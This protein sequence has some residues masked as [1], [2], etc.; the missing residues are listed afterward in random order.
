ME[1]AEPPSLFSR[2]GFH[3]ALMDWVMRDPKFK[4]QLFRFVDVLP[5][6]NSA[7]EVARH[8]HEYLGDEQVE[9]P[10][11]LRAAL[12][13]GEFAGGLLSGGIRSQVAS[14]A[15]QFMLGSDEGEIVRTLR[16]LHERNVAFTADILGETVVSEAE[17]DDYARRY[18]DLLDLLAREMARWPGPCRANLTPRGEV[19]ALNLSIKISALYS[20]IH[21]ADPDTAI[22]KLATRL[23]PILR[24]AGE[25][26][27]FINFDME[28]YALKDLTL[29]LFKTVFA[30]PEFATAPAC[31]LA[32]QA[33]MHDAET[34]LR[35][36]VAWA[37]T[38]QRRIT[39]RLVKGAYWDYETII[40][41]QRGWPVPVFARKAETDANFE[42]LTLFLLENAD[43][44][45]AAF[46]THNVRS[47]AHALA[48]ADRLGVERHAIE[49]QMLHG[50]AGALKSALLRLDLRVREYCPVGELLPGMAY[51][52][53]RLL[54][55]TSNEGFLAS[56]FAKGASREELLKAPVGADVR[57]LASSETKPEPPYVGS[58]RSGAIFQN[59][60]LTDFTR[61]GDREKVRA[62][63]RT[64]RSQLGCKHPLVINHKPVT[65]NEW[66]PS[67]NPA[68][69][70]EII[71][72]AARATV[73]D[74][75]AALA[76][77]RAAQPAWARLP[78]DERAVLLE[79]LAELLRRDKVAL[80]ALEIL[81]AGKNWAE[82]DAD[83]AEAI[84]FCNF[85]AAEMRV[86]GQPQR[87]QAVAGESNFQ[88]W[89][90]RGTGVVIAPWN[91]PLAILTGMATAALVTG[92]TVLIKPS[93]QTPVIG[94]RLMEL[95]I[96][97]GFPAGVANLV[98]GRGS[99]VGAHLVAHPQVD[100]IAFTGSTEVGQR[101]WE[102]AGRT[103]PGQTNLKRAVCEMGGKNSLI[104]DG[105][106]DLDEAVKGALI[107]AFGYQ[108]QKCS[109]LSRLIVLADNYDRFLER[110][111][112]AMASLR[113]G[114]AEEAG[115]IIGPVIDRVA[116]RRILEI[117]EVG[118]AE[119]TLAWQGAVSD[120]ANACYVPPTLFTD[121]KPRCRIFREEIFGPVLCVS[122]AASFDEALALAND[123]AFA[124]TGGVYSRSP[125]NIERAKSEMVCGNL[126]INRP[127]TGAIVGRQPFGG[128]KMSGGGTKAGG[129]EYLLQFLVPRVVSENCLRRGFAPSEES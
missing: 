111:V 109:A 114:P 29:R 85:Y 120:D 93:D 67:L 62:A 49:F 71:G 7:A 84:D 30:E 110:L 129:R 116:Q 83:V 92:N 100:F 90:S 22:E 91:F 113:V 59:E 60:P 86:V 52:V 78:A 97:A 68:N 47:I 69:Q 10:T 119:A 82:A 43:A 6:L 54:E 48:Q 3:G 75:E 5:A 25:V 88:H 118:K 117:I 105:D 112:A 108:G 74:A 64:L 101:I 4:T 102:A 81:E 61:G 127:I 39:V 16:H 32:L 34:D 36:L 45:D 33:Y 126:Y 18:L 107:S 46:G 13:A 63:L 57:R 123:S 104:V 20:Q 98:T 125:V 40:A 35:D 56:K 122:K 72:Y 80:T 44:V 65:T 37:R 14:L 103:L 42:K 79:R 9:L 2:K 66:T 17:A 19:P 53:R 70:N 121:V 28:S 31:G 87:T 95:I 50:M 99:E 12:K 77:A 89:W 58:Y 73:A 115:A 55:N 23:R 15:R 38:Q 41:A 124:L 26:G 8:L 27:A 51:L 76:A 24:R 1:E 106:A 11:T 128:F 94:A 96:E 21:P